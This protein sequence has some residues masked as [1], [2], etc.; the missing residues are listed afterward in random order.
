[1]AWKYV[2]HQS[3]CVG[4]GRLRR[5]GGWLTYQRSTEKKLK[6]K[7]GAKVSRISRLVKRPLESR[8]KVDRMLEKKPKP[9]P[10]YPSSQNAVDEE[11]KRKNNLRCCS[12][13]SIVACGLRSSIWKNINLIDAG[14]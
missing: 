13:I 12:Y 8:W 5:K 9:A 14:W 3:V 4:P 10:R 11:R 7:M 6:F 2:M 1:M